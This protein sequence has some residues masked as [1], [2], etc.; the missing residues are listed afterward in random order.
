M[1]SS[2]EVAVEQPCLERNLERTVNKS[3]FCDE[4]VAN[5]WGRQSE[6]PEPCRS[7]HC[8]LAGRPEQ[9]GNALLGATYTEHAASS[10]QRIGK[11]LHD[12]HLLPSTIVSSVVQ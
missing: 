6:V 10:L 2:C 5:V 4:N 11:W 12:P 3:P 9:A 7:I 8:W 1:L